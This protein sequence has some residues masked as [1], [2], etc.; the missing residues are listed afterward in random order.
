MLEQVPPQL[1]NLVKSGVDRNAR[2]AA[3]GANKK[4]DYPSV[5]NHAPYSGEDHHH[6]VII[7]IS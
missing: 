3:G 5:L 1:A 2:V 6:S 4:Q 7:D